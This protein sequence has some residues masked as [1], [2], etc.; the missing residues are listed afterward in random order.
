MLITATVIRLTVVVCLVFRLQPRDGQV[1]AVGGAVGGARE[2]VR[3]PRGPFVVLIDHSDGGTARAL[4]VPVHI[5]STDA[6]TAP[7]AG[8]DGLLPRRPRHGAGL[9]QHNLGPRSCK[10]EATQRSVRTGRTQFPGRLKRSSS[11]VANR[12]PPRFPP[13]YLLHSE[14]GR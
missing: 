7:G 4:L 5:V 9:S 1:G 11:Q 3:N 8:D 13:M 12:Q 6:A 2:P 10:E 14:Q